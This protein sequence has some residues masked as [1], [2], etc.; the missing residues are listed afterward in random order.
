[1]VK[2]KLADITTKFEKDFED[3]LVYN[4]PV[5]RIDGDKKEFTEEHYGFWF[6]NGYGAS[7]IRSPYTYGGP[8]LF[9][10]AV[11]IHDK[12]R[13]DDPCAHIITYDTPITDEVIGDLDE[14]AVS[15]ILNKIKGLD[16]YEVQNG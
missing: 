12:D 7:V 2:E 3:F 5:T 4:K 16:D 15:D 13:P 10:V 6:P 1:M 8:E 11:L 14:S 9:E